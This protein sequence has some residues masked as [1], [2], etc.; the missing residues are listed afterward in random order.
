M[1]HI[2]TRMVLVAITRSTCRQ[3][4]KRRRGILILL[5]KQ[6]QQSDL[7]S[8]QSNLRGRLSIRSIHPKYVKQ[9]TLHNTVADPVIQCLTPLLQIGVPIVSR[10]FSQSRGQS[11]S[12][13]LASCRLNLILVSPRIDFVLVTKHHDGTYHFSFCIV[14]YTQKSWVGVAMFDAGKTTNRS[15]VVLGPQRDFI[16]EIFESAA[17]RHPDL[18]PATYFSTPEWYNP[19][20]AKYGLGSWPGGLAHNAYNWSILEPYTGY[21][22]VEDY[23]QDIQ[24]PQMQILMDTYETNVL[25]CDIGGTTN[26]TELMPE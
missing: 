21:I 5:A 12:N 13:L 8:P 25:W 14:H 10:T 18:V 15:T 3:L 19:A 24:K 6:H 11:V 16:K 26:V 23:I 1:P 17:A 22:E 20:W 9:Y 2:F 4:V 7:G